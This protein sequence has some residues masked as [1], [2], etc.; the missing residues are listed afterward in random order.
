MIAKKHSNIVFA[1]KQKRIS[2][3]LNYKTGR[4]KGTRTL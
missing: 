4:M 2:K 1:K 3:K